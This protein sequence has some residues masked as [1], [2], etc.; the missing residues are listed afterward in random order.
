M[1][2]W[3]GL[4]EIY[5]WVGGSDLLGSPVIAATTPEVFAYF[6]IQHYEVLDPIEAGLSGSVASAVDVW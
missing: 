2:V 1:S 4:E 5:D 6:D 3:A